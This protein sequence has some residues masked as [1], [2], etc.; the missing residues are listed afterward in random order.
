MYNPGVQKNVQGFTCF[1]LTDLP[2]VEK[3]CSCAIRV[4]SAELDVTNVVQGDMLYRSKGKF[5]MSL[6]QTNYVDLLLVDNHTCLIRN[7][8]VFFDNSSASSVNSTF[9]DCLN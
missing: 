8:I 6:Q 2:D 9:Y 3:F 7:L 5:L 4:F 1:E